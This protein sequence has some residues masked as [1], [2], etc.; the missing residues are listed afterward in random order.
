MSRVIPFRTVAEQQAAARGVA[1]YLRNGGLIAYPTET[2]YGF[3]CA[4]TEPALAALAALKSRSEDKPFLILVLDTEI[5]G[6]E[7][8]PQALAMAREFWPGPLT[9]VLRA[10]PG[11]FPK[12]VADERNTVAVRA[13]PHP[14]V[15]LILEALGGPMTSTS[16]NLPG[17]MP[18]TSLEQARAV[19]AEIAPVVDVWLLDGGTLPASPPSTIV[20][21]SIQ[22]PRL[23]RRGAIDIAQ[24]AEIP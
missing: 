15:R 5:E 18:A 20:D 21:G 17:Q 12:Y 19:L 13:T 22:P 24:M 8:T 6:V 3:G 7:W 16:A 1:A 4:L 23:I 11:V 14:G 9:L 10:K 2:V